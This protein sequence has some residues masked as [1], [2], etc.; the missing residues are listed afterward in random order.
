MLSSNISSLRTTFILLC[1]AI[2][3][4][5]FDTWASLFTLWTNYD[6]AYSHGLLAVPLALL[7][8]Y[9]ANKQL[10]NQTRHIHWLA[11]AFL[12]ASS[13][14]WFLSDFLS[15]QVGA[16]LMIVPLIYLTVASIYGFKSA[17]VFVPA[18][19]YL[20]FAIPVWD[21][22][23]GLLQDLTTFVATSVLK[24]TELAVFIEG[25]RITIPYG[26]FEIAGGC[27][28]LRYLLVALVL[29]MYFSQQRPNTL[30][31]SLKLF[32]IALLFGLLANWIRVV[33]IILIG[34]ESEMQSSIVE[35]HE[36]FGWYVF[37]GTFIPAYWLLSQVEKRS[38]IKP[39][40]INDHSESHQSRT[41]V[42]SLAIVFLALSL[43]PLAKW[44]FA[45]QTNDTNFALNSSPAIPNW[46][47][48]LGATSPWQLQ[49][50][51]SQTLEP[52]VFVNKQ[53]ESVQING[54]YYQKQT[55][56]Q[57]LVGYHNRIASER[58][59][60]IRLAPESL[61]RPSLTDVRAQLISQD[62][63]ARKLIYSY[64]K[65]G[66]HTFVND[67]RTKI[68]QLRSIIEPNLFQG[69]IAYGIDCRGDCSAEAQTLSDF[70][71]AY[72]SKGSIIESA[73]TLKD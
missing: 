9:T 13:A 35:D 10:E 2:A 66:N 18:L 62:S 37:I 73:N 27:S 42:F 71:D 43:G 49:F 46:T 41:S 32:F 24:L 61:L 38:A 59:W 69:F 63:Q 65:I 6:L 4:A 5:L 47:T 58:N 3:L 51:G 67:L 21:Y 28:G 1:I 31:T 22:G 53:Y 29:V 17:L 25:N 11:L 54:A 44:G 12:A 70:I 39:V 15:I 36:V 68:A 14:V 34:Y 52:H 56:G 72:E 8:A 48:S 33:L 57:E 55:Q 40:Q 50:K 20:L 26:T 60:D 23:N 45:K 64:Y 7:S 19:I 16:Q 30:T